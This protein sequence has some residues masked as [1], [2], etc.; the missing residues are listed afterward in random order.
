[1]ALDQHKVL[2]RKSVELLTG[3]SRSSI[4]LMMS[5]DRFPKP[6]RL[7]K[8]AVGWREIDIIDWLDACAKQEEQS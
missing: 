7:G 8:R 2:R 6:I 3:L 5:E 4:Y 1:M